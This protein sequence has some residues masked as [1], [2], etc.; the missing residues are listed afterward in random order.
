MYTVHTRLQYDK[1]ILIFVPFRYYSPNEN[2]YCVRT[3]DINISSRLNRRSLFFIG[4]SA[5]F[6]LETSNERVRT[7]FFLLIDFSCKL[8]SWTLLKAAK[9]AIEFLIGCSKIQLSIIKK[10]HWNINQNRVFRDPKYFKKY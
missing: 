2:A 3:S 8:F 7:Y 4:L 10:Y 6:T 9:V 5:F 1:Y